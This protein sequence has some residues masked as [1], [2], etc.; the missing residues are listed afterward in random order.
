MHERMAWSVPGYVATELI[1]FGA[2]GEVWRARS[3]RDGGLVA[4]KRLHCAPSAADLV[5][6]RQR[7]V[8]LAEVG[9]RH[10]LPIRAVLAGAQATVLVLDYATG[11]SLA[12][13]L[14]RRGRLRPGELVTV[15]VPLA[16]ALDSL[17][18][19]GIPHGSVHPAN[20][21]FTVD[22]RPLL[23]EPELPG[24]ASGRSDP[25]GAPRPAGPATDVLMLARVAGQAL[26]GTPT[27]PD[28]DDLA[29]LDAP[30]PLVRALRRALS[31]DPGERGTAAE[32]ALAVR[33]SCEPEPVPLAGPP[34]GPVVR[35]AARVVPAGPRHRWQE[36]PGSRRRQGRWLAAAA[37]LAVACGSVAWATGGAAGPSAG[38]APAGPGAATPLTSARP[39]PARDWLAVLDRLDAVRSRAYERGDPAL[40]RKVYLPG[41]HLRA[42]TAQLGRITATGETVRGVRHRLRLVAVESSV[43]GQ[44]R[45]R[46]AQSLPVS[47]RLRSGHPLGPVPGRPES[48]IVVELTLSPDGWR[49]A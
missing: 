37:V 18:G 23:A 32:F 2:S 4:L 48:V 16:S 33:A 28:P 40:L 10:L 20:V 6:L 11:G 34:V 35:P 44:V 41:S 46:V 36:P 24:V 21:L 27:C 43:P 5:A 30:A 12:M 38:A 42:D 26:A 19:N 47:L 45:L 22:G 17:H 15:L 49:L 13:L 8:S 3:V 29:G 7:V 25:D 31:L 14:R 39:V 1:G 9:Q